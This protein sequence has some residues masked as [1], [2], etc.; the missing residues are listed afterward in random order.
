MM[1][2]SSTALCAQEPSL[3]VLPPLRFAPCLA[4]SL[5]RKIA[6]RATAPASRSKTIHP[7]LNYQYAPQRLECEN[8]IYFIPINTAAN[9]WFVRKSKL[10]T[11]MKRRN[12]FCSWTSIFLI[13]FPNPSSTA[14]CM[15]ETLFLG[16]LYIGT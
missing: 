16:S 7:A 6:E 11:N 10:F 1:F 9:N 5:P 13:A 12:A 4:A 14:F 2:T 15:K 3:H 8:Y